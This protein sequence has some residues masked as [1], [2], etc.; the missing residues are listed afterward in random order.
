MDLFESAAWRLAIAEQ[1][2]AFGCIYR[3]FGSLAKLRNTVGR[4]AGS[5]HGSDMG[6]P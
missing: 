5:F 4:Q 1:K 6:A 2:K 3:N